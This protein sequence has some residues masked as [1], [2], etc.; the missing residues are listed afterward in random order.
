MDG[1]GKFLT[2]FTSPQEM[3]GE[4]KKISVYGES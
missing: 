1:G 2:E 3:R 4:E